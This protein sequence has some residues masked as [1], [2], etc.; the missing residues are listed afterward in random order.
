MQDI[1]VNEFSVRIENLF[2]TSETELSLSSQVEQYNKLIR[3]QVE[4]MAP[5]QTREVTARP[6]ALWYSDELRQEKQ[7]RRR[8]ERQYRKTNLVVH[9]LLYKDQCDV[10]NRCLHQAKVDYHRGQVEDADSKSLF[11]VVKS[12]TQ[13]KS[14]TVLPKHTCS[15]SMA[16]Q[17]AKYFSDKI[18]TLRQE[19]DKTTVGNTSIQ[20]T[21]QT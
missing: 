4:Q 10:Y 12:L 19:L 5:L 1:S 11:Q 6:K 3:E 15:Q 13:P 18:S 21:L 7:L 14:A 8:L 17:F 16:N 20:A 2:S 9:Y